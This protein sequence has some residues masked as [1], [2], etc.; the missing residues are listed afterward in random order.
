MPV[1]SK[2]VDF[3]SI[4]KVLKEDETLNKDIKVSVN[5]TTMVVKVEYLNNA[6]EENELETDEI[7]TTSRS[8]RKKKKVNEVDDYGLKKVF[9]KFREDSNATITAAEFMEVLDEMG[10][11]IS[12]SEC[13][14]LKRYADI[15]GDGRLDLKEFLNMIIYVF[16]KI[17]DTEEEVVKAFKFFDYMDTD[18]I[19][20]VEMRRVLTNLGDKLTNAEIDAFIQKGDLDRDG[21]IN[22][23]E[24]AS[25]M[26]KQSVQYESINKLRI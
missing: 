9:N 10:Y 4:S 24:F 25:K 7:V 16:L 1:H 21:N 2:Q 26:N 13:V 23:A 6:K 17:E 18:F 8:V 15:D 14:E 19:P 12:R 11:K 3:R 5:P 22:Y 20:S